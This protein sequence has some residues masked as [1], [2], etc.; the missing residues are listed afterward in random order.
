MSLSVKVGLPLQVPPAV[1]SALR[2]GRMRAGLSTAELASAAGVDG[3]LVFIVEHGQPLLDMT[4]G[5]AREPLERIWAVLELPVSLLEELT[6]SWSERTGTMPAVGTTDP[7]TRAVDVAATSTA[8]TYGARRPVGPEAP[9]L[10]GWRRSDADVLPTPPGPRRQPDARNRAGR[11]RTG[12]P[13]HR[14]PG[15]VLGTAIGVTATAVVGAAVSVI[16]L[17]GN[18][19]GGPPPPASAATAGATASAGSA[20]SPRSGALER[21]GADSATYRTIRASYRLDISAV[22]PCW[23]EVT[24][25]SGQ[26]RWAGMLSA[27]RTERLS[28]QGPVE[29]QLG[30]GGGRLVV[31]SGGRST[32]LTPPA[33]PYTYTVGR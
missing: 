8:T 3:G 26:S 4:P 21:T 10:T 14:G 27:G 22:A 25:I 29:V 19:A 30:S 16:V 17:S 15:R 13:G 9:T 12:R 28:E 7:P 11:V 31:I 33:A 5:E 32:T 6:P 24:S 2:Q 23:A 1:S 18:G 20:A